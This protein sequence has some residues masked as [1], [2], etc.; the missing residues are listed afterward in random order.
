MICEVRSS[1]VLAAAGRGVTARQLGHEWGRGTAD[2]PCIPACLLP[3][4][5]VQCAY[6]RTCTSA[7][8]HMHRIAELV[9]WWQAGMQDSNGRTG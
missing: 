4:Y 7:S 2:C 1:S 5:R 6:I 3:T 8:E 9:K